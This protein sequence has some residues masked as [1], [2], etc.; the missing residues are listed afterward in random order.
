MIRGPEYL[1]KGKY[2]GRRAK[3]C[4][5][6]TLSTPRQAQSIC[7]TRER[8]RDGSNKAAAAADMFWRLVLTHLDRAVQ[9]R[10]A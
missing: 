10:L 3:P 8:D 7:H 9:H 1:G 2:R 4:N 5:R 6:F